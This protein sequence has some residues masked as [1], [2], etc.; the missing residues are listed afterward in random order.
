MNAVVALRAF[1]TYH[2][3]ISVAGSYLS[4][5]PA[6]QTSRASS[7]LTASFSSGTSTVSPL[8]GISVAERARSGTANGQAFNL[9]TMRPWCL[10]HQLIGF[11]SST[12]IRLSAFPILNPITRGHSCRMTS[13][14]VHQSACVR[15]QGRGCIPCHPI[16]G[17]SPMTRFLRSDQA[18]YTNASGMNDL[19]PA[20]EGSADFPRRRAAAAEKSAVRWCLVY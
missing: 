4:H 18:V 7:P 10:Y 1:V 12:H 6:S 11:P 5:S 2:G 20:C 19:A 17:P 9:V 15:V 8:S 14:Y 3:R 16:H 13:T